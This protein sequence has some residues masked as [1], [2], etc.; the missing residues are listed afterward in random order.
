MKHTRLIITLCLSAVCIFT[1]VKLISS[2]AREGKTPPDVT[3]AGT[4]QDANSN[5]APATPLAIPCV[6]PPGNTMVAWYPFDEPSN[7][8]TEN[9]ATHNIGKLIGGP[10]HITGKVSDALNFDGVNDYV[11]SPSSIVTNIGP[12]AAG[13]PASGNFSIDAWIRLPS[14]ATNSVVV[15]LDKRSEPPLI[16]YHFYLSFKRIGLELADVNGFTNY[17]SNIIMSLTDTQWHHIAVTVNRLSPTGITFYH[18]GVSAGTADPMTHMGTLGNNSPLRIGT[19]TANPPLTGW[20][21]GDI[22]EL[23]IFNREL[24]EPEVLALYTAQE[25]G[26]CKPFS[27]PGAC[28]GCNQ[29][30]D[31]DRD[32]KFDAAVF[33]PSNGYWYISYSSGGS[34]S[35]HWGLATDKIVPGAYNVAGMTDIAVYRNGTWYIVGNPLCCTLGGANDIPVPR[36]YDGDGKTDIAV[37]QSSPPTWRIILSSNG[38]RLTVSTPAANSTD[39]P[40]PADY[41]GDCKADFAVWRS[42]GT[43]LLFDEAGNLIFSVVPWAGLPGDKPIPADYDGDGKAD[44]AIWRPELNG[45]ATFHIM[46]SRGGTASVPFGTS[47]DQPVPACYDEDVK[48]DIAVYRPETS[49]WYI[50]RSMNQTVTA[51]QY[52]LPGDIPVV[53]AYIR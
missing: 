30:S 44:F 32:T 41:D 21:R 5:A 34:L 29:L 25:A 35:M 27:I 26:K 10:T 23:E 2:R 51:Y 1:L 49:V 28:L 16:G 52:G 8:V 48:A 4:S 3:Q 20:F 36:D 22:D 53:S 7:L 33:R 31:F 15:I 17:T 45:T 43:W 40:V 38:G 13:P 12:A 50:L 46:Y 24:T 42:N 14:D 18:N 6:T 9:L 11:E 39:I 37:W 19:R 47:T